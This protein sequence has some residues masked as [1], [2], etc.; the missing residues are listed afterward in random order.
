MTSKKVWSG[1]VLFLFILM[2]GVFAT[3]YYISLSN[4][5]IP[6]RGVFVKNEFKICM[7]V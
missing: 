7:G 1:I 4:H 3:W 5:P 6:S 2:I